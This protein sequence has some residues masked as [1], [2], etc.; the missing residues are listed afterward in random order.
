MTQS[1]ETTGYTVSDH[2]SAVLEHTKCP[3]LIDVVVVND[4]HPE[5][6][7]EKYK[8]QN[9]EP[10]VIDAEK[11]QKLGIRIVARNLIRE[12]DLVRHNPKLL[13]KAILLWHRRW[14][15]Y[16]LKKTR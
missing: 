16:P 11:I 15:K 13:T 2:V 9:Q 14:Q 10:V 4:R 7:L 6:L 5:V 3:D 8:E 12:E 1:G